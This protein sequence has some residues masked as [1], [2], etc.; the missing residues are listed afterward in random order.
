MNTT[1]L[2]KLAWKIN[3]GFEELQIKVLKGKYE[4]NYNWNH[5]AKVK[6]SN[7]KSQ[8]D[9]TNVWKF[10]NEGQKWLVKTKV[11][12][13]FGRMNGLEKQA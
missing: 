13:N 3:M 8:K 4:R 1:C 6:G 11:Q 9:I 12:L 2:M 5:N 7:L 10:M